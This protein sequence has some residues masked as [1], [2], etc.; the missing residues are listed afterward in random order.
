MSNPAFFGAVCQAVSDEA[1]DGLG[2]GQIDEVA[3]VG[4]HFGGFELSEGDNAFGGH[5]S[6]SR[7]LFRRKRKYLRGG[8][9]SGASLSDV[10]VD[11]AWSHGCVILAVRIKTVGWLGGTR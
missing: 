2:M 10:W 5:G 11:A 4:D 3:A 1:V 8:F 7:G 6:P 9:T